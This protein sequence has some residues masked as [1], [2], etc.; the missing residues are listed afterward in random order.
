MAEKLEMPV[1]G[2]V[3][4][5]QSSQTTTW[6]SVGEKGNYSEENESIRGNRS[7]DSILEKRAIR[8][9]DY[10]LMPIMTMFYLLSFLVG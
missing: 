6:I 5:Q 10:L 9:L 2:T 3:T 7:I 8:K 1:E 4:G